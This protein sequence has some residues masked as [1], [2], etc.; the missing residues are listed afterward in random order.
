MTAGIKVLALLITLLFSLSLKAADYYWVGGSGNWSDISHWVSSSGGT[1]NYSQVPTPNDNVYFDANSFTGANQT[2]VL[3]GLYANC[4]NLSI[5]NIPAT[6]A[7]ILP[8]ANSFKIYGS[9]NLAPNLN[10]D[11]QGKF[12]FEATT[13][14]QTI[15]MGGHKIF[16]DVYFQGLG[17]SWTL[18]D[19]LV[20]EG[21]GSGI[22]HVY[23]ALNTS[24]K[25]VRCWEYISNYSN[26]RSLSLGSSQFWIMG[27]TFTSLLLNSTNFTLIAGSST[28]HFNGTAAGYLLAGSNSLSFNHI[29]FHNPDVAK[30][31]H[32]TSTGSVS[33][34]VFTLPADAEFLGNQQF[35]V[36]NL[37]N[38]H[39]YTFD[40]AATYTF[41]TA[42]NA[43]GACSKSLYLHSTK[44]GFASTFHKTSGSISLVDVVIY[45]IQTSGAA[46]FTATNSVNLGNS[47]GWIITQP[48]ARTLYWVGGSG[49]WAD[50]MHWSTS[51]GGP[52][53]ACL[54]RP[55]DDVYFNGASFPGTGATVSL[56]NRIATCKSMSWVGAGNSPDFGSNAGGLLRIYGSLTFIP[57]MNLSYNGEVRFEALAMGN[58]ITSAGRKFK[59]DVIFDGFGGGWTLLDDFEILLPSDQIVHL[60]GTLNTNGK[61]VTTGTFLGDVGARTLIL[62]SSV[63]KVMSSGASAWTLNSTLC[64]LNAGTSHIIFKTTQGGMLNN[65]NN[66]LVYNNVS[67]SDTS[68]QSTLK[69]ENP[70]TTFNVVTFNQNGFIQGYNIVDTMVFAP[71]KTYDLYPTD[72][73]RIIGALDAVGNCFGYIVIRCFSLN[74]VTY[75]RKDGGALSTNFTILS[76]VHAIGTASFTAYNTISLG[77]NLNW[78]IVPMNSVALYWVGGSGNWDDPQHWSYTSGGMP[79]ACIP[80]PLNDVYFDM[81]SFN[82]PNQTVNV[83]VVQAFC[84]NMSWNGALYS[85]AL[86]SVASNNLSIYG[87]LQW[88]PNMTQGFS[89]IVYF[90]AD[91]ASH[92]INTGSKAFNNDLF[93]QSQGNTT[94]TLASELTVN[95]RIQMYYKGTFNTAG[96]NI[97]AQRMAVETANL[98]QLNLGSSI[99]TLTSSSA[100]TLTFNGNNLSI[101]QGTSEFRLTG[102]TPT[103]YFNGPINY[104]LHDLVSTDPNG[105]ILL[106]NFST[107]TSAFNRV[108]FLGDATIRG[109]NSF[110]TLTFTPGNSYFLENGKTQFIGNEF[111]I[112]GNNC[113]PII[114]RSTNSGLQA[115]IHKSGTAVSGDFIDMRDQ[116]AIGGAAFYAGNFSTNVSNNNGWIFQNLPGYVYGLG[117]DT[118]ICP[119]D[120]LILSTINFNGPSSVQWYNAAST[121]TITVTQPGTYW[122]QVFYASSCQLS[123]TIVVSA[124]SGLDSIQTNIGHITCNN[125]NNGWIKIS[126][127]GSATPYFQWSNGHTTDSIYG[128]GPG[129]YSVII[130]DSTCTEFFD[131]ISLTNPQP[132]AMAFDS[133]YSVCGG[134]RWIKAEALGGVGPYSF[135]WSNGAVTDSIYGL[136]VGIYYV[137]ITDANGCNITASATVTADP[138]LIPLISNSQNLLCYQDATGTATATASGGWPPYQVYWN[139]IP[140]Q[141]G[142]SAT[143]LQAGTYYFVVHDSHLCI[144][145]VAVTITEPQAL[146][147]SLQAKNEGCLDDCDGAV[148][149]TLSGG[150]SPYSYQ[151]SNS[152]TSPGPGITNIC[153][154][155]YHL[156]ITDANQCQITASANVATNTYINADFSIDSLVGFIPLSVQLTFLGSGAASYLWDFG[157]GGSSTLPNPNHTYLQEGY[158]PVILTVNSGSPDFCIDTHTDTIQTIL[159]RPRFYI[160]NTFTPNGDGLNDQFEIKSVYIRDI[161]VEIFN[162]WGQLLCTWNDVNGSWDGRDASGSLAPVGAYVYKITASGWDNV[163]HEQLGTI[164]MM[165]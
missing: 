139:S 165:Y 93:F 97:L 69:S 91:S 11:F 99:I 85:P 96:Y 105:S 16:N 57:A 10:L 27:S 94:W 36:L 61:T 29:T 88:I 102:A 63:I 1:T 72:T 39:E 34:N 154:G 152:P 126:T 95:G 136:N 51:S 28:I 82:A 143:N 4:H 30:K 147:L 59:E 107:D 14:G 77:N 162:R 7:I 22:Y 60:N 52:G 164:T 98:R 76:S 87:S 67:F 138:Q 74:S 81:N 151:W 114:L 6:A 120:T 86:S 54:P 103:V 66:H 159:R 161:R 131:T 92:I 70:S 18:A 33:F 80:T 109:F 123:D 37:S 9:I 90:K 38:D 135:S 31:L 160:P 55:I 75:I 127:Y 2:V 101:S 84:R 23:G 26:P 157:D 133:N 24:G 141:N 40:E 118:T 42:L 47:T 153:P 56:N 163:V 134:Q 49:S 145:S 17:G 128:L 150:T 45:D 48:A 83:N 156:T 115:N 15:N 140:Q 79:G 41:I 43:Q 117:Y 73:L 21:N 132:L 125:G 64:T 119:G 108:V 62:G 124:N 130:T 58:T 148:S 129:T 155:T 89:G 5:S 121:P 12:Y 25:L 35:N 110:D 137:T 122:V 32:N 20:L 116:N 146:S 50:S 53:G 46:V 100:P 144:D 149:S 158:F 3:N 68:S 142:Y 112:R 106:N 8:A 71:N 13:G 44:K 78:T 65:G 111:N 113:F 19:S 104:A